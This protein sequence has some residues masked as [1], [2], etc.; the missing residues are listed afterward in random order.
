M[1]QEPLFAVPPSDPVALSE[2]VRQQIE[3]WLEVMELENRGGTDDD[4]S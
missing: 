4:P 1:Q 3:R 2:E